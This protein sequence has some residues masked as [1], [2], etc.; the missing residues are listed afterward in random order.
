[1]TSDRRSFF[2]NQLSMFFPNTSALLCLFLAAS[3]SPAQTARSAS[4]RG[5]VTDP[6]GSVVPG[7]A[8]ILS[9]E[10]SAQNT[11]QTDAHG[12]YQFSNLASGVYTV[13]VSAPGF[14]PF[15]S[16][17]YQVLPGR[18]QTFDI[19]M[20]LQAQSEQVTVSANDVAKLD[21]DP[22]TNA[23]ALVLG[24]T[25]MEALPDDP[26]DLSAD[27]QALAGPAAGPDGAQFFIDGFT[28]GRLPPKS[29]IR[30]IR[31]NQDPFAAQFDHPGH[32]RVEILT[33]P[34]TNDF[35]GSVLFQFGNQAMNSRDPFLRAKPPYQRRLWQGDVSGPLGKRTSFSLD[36]ERRDIDENAI[37]NAFVL[38]SDLIPTPFTQ[39]VVTPL[40]GTEG[41]FKIDRQLS[42]NH[43]LT[44][45]YGF[46]R[47]S[48]AN[49][50]VGGFSLPDRAYQTKG[51]EQTFQLVETA[52]L[53]QHS[54]TETRF[55][56]RHRL[57]GHPKPAIG[58]H[59]K[60][61]QWD[62]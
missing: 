28:G 27:L 57:G 55:R 49:G 54:V 59:F 60:T 42:T 4:L 43:T 20:N 56:Y 47:D 22:S 8:V 41:N 48:N 12:A 39:A 45:R 46:A 11:A 53:N 34:G 23:G 40:T 30:E 19:K 52:V 51:T 35:H 16:P 33:K 7:A 2:T 36:F 25:D 5:V 32:G 44:A 15:Q 17:G 37:V 6:S 50:G 21:T 29:S 9:S 3:V 13:R 31:V 61:G 26:D 58:G 14:S 62:S 1:M 38:N 24:R 10:E 18:A